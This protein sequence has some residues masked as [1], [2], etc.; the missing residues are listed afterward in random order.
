MRA[1][2]LFAEVTAEIERLFQYS[3]VAD[4]IAPVRFCVSQ[5][6]G[7]DTRIDIDR[8]SSIDSQFTELSASTVPGVIDAGMLPLL[9]KVVG[10]S[11]PGP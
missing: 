8:P 9:A 5:R 1:K 7:E 4:L 2:K 3:V 6:D 11:W 10:S